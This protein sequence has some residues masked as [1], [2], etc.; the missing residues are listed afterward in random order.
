MVRMV[1]EPFVCTASRFLKKI[2]HLQGKDIVNMTDY[3]KDLGT[4]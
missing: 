4:K 1:C 3:N 2:A